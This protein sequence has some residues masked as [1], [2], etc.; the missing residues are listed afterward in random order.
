MTT[1]TL[2]N[3]AAAL[4]I[5]TV[6]FNEVCAY[7]TDSALRMSV[8]IKAVA[9]DGNEAL[10]GRLC[11]YACT[12]DDGNEVVYL[13]EMAM[14]MVIDG[15]AYEAAGVLPVEIEMLLDTEEFSHTGVWEY[16]DLPIAANNT[17]NTSSKEENTMKNL[18]EM[19]KTELIDLAKANGIKYSGLKKDELIAAIQFFTNEERKESE[20]VVSPVAEEAV[21][22]AEE[23]KSV[24][25]PEKKRIV[26]AL[27]IAWVYQTV[28]S[29]TNDGR[30]LFYKP[31]KR[32]DL[33]G[34]YISSEKRL[35]KVTG[36]LLCWM[37]KKKLEGDTWTKWVNRAYEVA[38]E[39]G[40]CHRNG[41][42]IHMTDT[43]RARCVAIYNKP[44]YKECIKRYADFVAATSKK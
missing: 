28:N 10:I 35:A 19:K 13:T 4:N 15:V 27:A 8:A 11:R 12:G 30:V 16:V 18:K 24:I 32:V 14:I 25:T 31:T 23:K 2:S 17:N 1:T 29:V 21:P 42:D 34:N 33:A 43:E 41:N 7:T 20:A 36:D 6:A 22:V 38:V 40:I 5:N 26:E 9:E 39:Y 44:E 3:I 37:Y